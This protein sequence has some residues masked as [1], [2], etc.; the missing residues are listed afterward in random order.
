MG[1]GNFFISTD[2]SSSFALIDTLGI[3]SIS[4]GLGNFLISTDTSSS[5]APIDTHKESFRQVADFCASQILVQFVESMPHEAL[6]FNPHSFLVPV[7]RLLPVGTGTGACFFG[8]RRGSA[9]RQVMPASVC[10]NPASYTDAAMHV[11]RST[12]VPA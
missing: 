7:V 4:M 5:F 11:P 3:G 9:T 6:Y 10:A 8:G 1:L 12:P 2:T